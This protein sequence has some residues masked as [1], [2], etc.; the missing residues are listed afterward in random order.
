M[1]QLNMNAIGIENY[2]AAKVHTNFLIEMTRGLNK[3]VHQPGDLAQNSI[4]QV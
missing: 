4:M 3:D 2:D 1:K